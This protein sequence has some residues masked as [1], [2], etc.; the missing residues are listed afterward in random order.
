M[1]LACGCGGTDAGPRPPPPIA[2]HAADTVE[3][4]RR[5][6]EP[7][8]TPTALPRALIDGMPSLG[9]TTLA[10]GQRRRVGGVDLHYDPS[11]WIGTAE[12]GHR[13]AAFVFLIDRAEAGEHM[14]YGGQQEL[15]AGSTFESFIGPYRIE[16]HA[17][18]EQPPR[19]V[20]I[21]VERRPCPDHTVIDP[22]TGP[23]WMWLSTD[24]IFQHT[25]DLQGQLLQVVLQPRG[26]VPHIE[27]SAFGWRH[28]MTPE[29]DHTRSFRIDNRIVTI[30]R[31][32]P[33]RG[34]RFEG[35]WRSRGTAHVN[36]LVRV[37]PA[38]PVAAAAAAVAPTTGCGAPA[39]VRTTLPAELTRAL[40]Q[41]GPAIVLAAGDRGE[42]EGLALE[43]GTS[44]LP[45]RPGRS[46]LEPERFI[47]LSSPSLLAPSIVTFAVM[48]GLPQLARADRTMLLVELDGAAGTSRELR[49]RAFPLA[50][51][52]AAA[53]VP[54]I[55][56]AT[57]LW[58]STVGQSLFTVGDTSLP[59]LTLQVHADPNHP[60][61]SATT[62]NASDS[63]NL[64]ATLVG[65]VATLDGYRIEI[66]DVVADAST[67]RTTWGWI[68]DSGVPAVHVQ[69]R[70]S[71]PARGSATAS[72]ACNIAPCARES[73]WGFR[74]PS[75][76]WAR[77]AAATTTPWR[78]TAV[79]RSTR[80]EPT[81]A[82]RCSTPAR[83]TTRARCPT[84][85]RARAPTA[86]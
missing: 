35:A 72:G 75:D 32:V 24:A 27:I 65:H 60:S 19:S 38:P 34:T 84:P 52:R 46:D 6:G 36:A 80:V 43:V 42:L 28:G 26:E 44:E 20:R 86:G 73:R 22:P 49:V 69:F 1:A 16:G 56:D 68:V 63:G 25:L 82:R 14:P 31:V 55:V 61:F 57:Y 54:R 79:A 81:P 62:Q 39:P 3:P 13:G 64:A 9:A 58:L 47:R 18:A 45:R 85:G 37:E 48:G 7:G 12:V 11:A 71:P 17:S 83:T 5:C 4:A 51:A 30:E 21:S 29:P 2:R 76:C 10:S 50:C 74:W 77:P 41:H 33:G 8:P 15:S 67:R 70:V 40:V 23:I 53:P 66:V 78:V 59:A